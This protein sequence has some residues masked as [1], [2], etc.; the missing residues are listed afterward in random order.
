LDVIFDLGG[1]LL[2]WDPPA[3]LSSVFEDPHERARVLDRLFGD[4]DWI[5]LDRGTLPVPA[6]I[7]LVRA[8]RAAGNRLFVLSNMHRASV[9]HLEAAYDL[10]ALFDGRGRLLRR[11]RVQAGGGHLPSP[12]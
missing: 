9:A 3:M 12:P 6:A 8:L 2:T 1:V 11:R 7:E 10:F 4:P 5:E